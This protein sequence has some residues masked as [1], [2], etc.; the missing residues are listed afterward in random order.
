M[1]KIWRS[2]SYKLR[3]TLIGHEA[4]VRAVAPAV[5]PENG[6]LTVSR[7]LSC[8]VWSPEDSNDFRE[9]HIFHGHTRYVAAVCTMPPTDEH[10]QGLVITGG[11]DNLVLVFD[12]T[13]LEPIQRLEGH[14]A[15]VCSLDAGKWGTI[16]SGS[17]DNTARVWNR[18]KTVLQLS[19]HEAAIWSVKMI[20]DKGLMLTGS[21]DKTIKMWKAGKCERTFTGHKDC[22]RCL[23]ILSADEFLSCSNDGT[24]RRWILSGDC[25]QIY[26]SHTNFVYSVAVIPNTANM[27][28][29]SGEDRTVRVWKDDCCIQTITLPCQSVWSVSALQN[30]D[31]I[32]GSS[33]AVARVFTSDERRQASDDK[34]KEF[35][36][37]VANQAIPAAASLDLGE[38]KLD[39]L[40]GPEALLRPGKRNDETKLVKRNGIVE[41]HQWDAVNGRWQ[42]VGEVTGAAG[43]EG[44]ERTAGKKLYG[45]K[46]YDYVFNVD[47][48]EG[49]PPLKLPFNVT[50]DPWMAAQTFLEKNNIS[51]MF[52]DQVAN[53]IIKN[54]EG[55]TLG[56]APPQYSDPFTGAGMYVPQSSST[57]QNTSSGI[58]PFTGS[59]RYVP[60]TNVQAGITYFPEKSYLK[61]SAGKAEQIILKMKEFNMQVDQNF[62]ITEDE[63]NSL[64]D[65][66]SKILQGSSDISL[67]VATYI[68]TIFSK[69]IQ[70]PHDKLLPVLDTVR[71]L[72]L[73]ENL[74]NHFIFLD[75]HANTFID[76]LLGIC[77]QSDQPTNS[78][79]IYRTF[80]NAFTHSKGAGAVYR[81]REKIVEQCEVLYLK[82]HK[83][84]SISMSSFIVNCCVYCRN[85]SIGFEDRVQLCTYVNK[86]LS[87]EQDDNS[88]FRLLVSLGTLISDNE[89]MIMFVKTLEL[90][91]TLQLLKEQ[92]NVEKVK[93]CILQLE[94]LLS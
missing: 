92:I 38:I 69:L 48:E 51:Q 56:A 62:Q 22:V 61:F 21:A 44:S 59:G 49:K 43:Q 71:I 20:E 57:T 37:I 9:A 24:I 1:T 47:I 81:N 35:E 68:S 65:V 88:I 26:E 82:N 4:D 64:S 3:S 54:T 79:L 10:P 73:N 46:E 11:H 80:T 30:G 13:S 32:A 27:F 60:Q 2:M 29:S 86:F 90:N 89:D 72:V 7:D 17:W 42:K 31:I 41:A 84:L 6:I 75:E 58:D 5:F 23:A 63:V 83:N 34:I 33:D 53:F 28:V 40:P 74:S 52:L 85:S 70:W 14:T 77:R 25:I 50:D 93:G 12:L 16:L 39:Q 67:D 45:G 8:R 76:N 91:S 94:N 18:G 87:K 19:D 15:T 66:T 78:M 36:D 55:V